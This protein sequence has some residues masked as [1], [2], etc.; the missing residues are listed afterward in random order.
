MKF[1]NII[2]IQVVEADNV[3]HQMKHDSTMNINQNTGTVSINKT[4]TFVQ[5]LLQC[6]NQKS[7]T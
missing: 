5:P 1:Q 4:G 3:S 7:I 2:H 6:E